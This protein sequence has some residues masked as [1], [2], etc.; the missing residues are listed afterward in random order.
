[1]IAV[2]GTRSQQQQGP[3]LEMNCQLHCHGNIESSGD[4]LKAQEGLQRRRGDHDK[5]RL[6]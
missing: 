1:M 4:I 6:Q 2:L 3:A 5:R